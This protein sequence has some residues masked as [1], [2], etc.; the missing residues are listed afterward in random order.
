MYEYLIKNQ[1]YFLKKVNS[2]VF[3]NCLK[4]TIFS[5]LEYN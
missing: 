4:L 5:S 3:K 2:I 1:I